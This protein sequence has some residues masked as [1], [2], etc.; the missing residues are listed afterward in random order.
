M[1]L[2]AAHRGASGHAPENTMAAFHA[3]VSAGAD[4]IELDVRFTRD[5][6]PI[7]IHDRTLARTTGGRGQVSAL[8][9]SE[10]SDADAGSWFHP[11][12]A[13]ERIPTL[14]SVLESLPSEIGINIEVKPDGDGRP[15]HV[16]ARRLSDEIRAHQRGREVLVSSF[17]HR[18]LKVFRHTAPH[19]PLGVLLH[20]VRDLVRRPVLIARRLDAAYIFC[21]RSR[22]RRSM[23]EAAHDGGFSVGV[24]TVNESRMIPRLARFGVDL[25]F[26]NYPAEIRAALE[27]T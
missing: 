7:V 3:A 27:R 14:A 9:L 1:M 15:L 20:P 12:F 18:F 17:D 23:V 13:N 26:T 2:V 5:N 16:L 21:S 25:V 19:V 4:L 24:Y 10:L 8:S 22:V 6:V 11:R